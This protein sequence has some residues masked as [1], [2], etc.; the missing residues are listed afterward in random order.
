MR[1]N[2]I[3]MVVG[4][5][6]FA[7]AEFVPSASSCFELPHADGYQRDIC[8]K[9][10]KAYLIIE[11]FLPSCSACHRNVGQFKK[12]ES[13]THDVAHSRLIS[14][15]DLSQTLPFIEQH[16]IS[17]DVAL[18]TYKQ[19]K[20]FFGIG[21]VP[22]IVILDQHNDVVY[23]STGYLEDEEIYRIINLIMGYGS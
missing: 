5:A 6:S 7:R 1:F 3:L 9:N 13:L 12:L 16:A 15:R 20:G 4:M 18:D 23:R 14:L 21:G 8:G 10:G 22:A 19:A 2:F 11:F 17:T